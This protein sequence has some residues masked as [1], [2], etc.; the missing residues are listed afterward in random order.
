MQQ[1]RHAG[2]AAREGRG[3]GADRGA[4]VR[5]PAGAAADG[6]PRGGCA[7]RHGAG[8]GGG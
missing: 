8:R 1:A 5:G 2:V 3:G 6:H 4:R 7:Q